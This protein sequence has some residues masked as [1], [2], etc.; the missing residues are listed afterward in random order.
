MEITE[1]ENHSG[2]QKKNQKQRAKTRKRSQ[3]TEMEIFKWSIR[4]SGLPELQTRKA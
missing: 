3:I 2:L 4:H 1:P